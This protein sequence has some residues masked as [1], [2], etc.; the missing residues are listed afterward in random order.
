MCSFRETNR[1]EMSQW[2]YKFDSFPEFLVSLAA[3]VLLGWL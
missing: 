1:E 3:M 2:D